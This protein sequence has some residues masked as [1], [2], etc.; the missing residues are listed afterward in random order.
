MFWSHKLFFKFQVNDVDGYERTA[1]HYAAER[2][3]LTVEILLQHG[4]DINARDGNLDTPLHWAAFKNNLE[5]VKLLLQNG[6]DVDAQDFNLDTPL[7]WS[8][9][10][11]HLLVIKILLEYNASV[12]L[13]NLHGDTPLMRAAFIQVSGLN[14]DTDDACLELLLKASGQF[15]IRTENGQ[16]RNKIEQDNKLREMLIPLC[17]NVRTLQDISRHSL[18]QRLGYRFLPN[19]IPKLPIPQTLR[20]FVLLQR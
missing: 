13:K 1:L 10:K 4:A 16:L 11:G 9:R 6:A 12:D 20:E 8:S 2:D 5:C 18:R 15:D 7:S 17:E 3:A 14:T 19:V